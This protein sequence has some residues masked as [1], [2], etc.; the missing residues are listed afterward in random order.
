LTIG[1]ISI[2]ETYSKLSLAD[3]RRLKRLNA[4]NLLNY[5][6]KRSVLGTKIPADDLSTLQSLQK[7][8]LVLTQEI[9]RLASTERQLPLP[10]RPLCIGRA[11]D[12]TTIQNLLENEQRRASTVSIEGFGGIGKTVLAKETAHLIQGRGRYDKIIWMSAK[13]SEFINGSITPID[14]YSNNLSDLLDV[15][16]ESFGV[17]DISTIESLAKKASIARRHL[18]DTKTLVIIDNLETVADFNA[19]STFLAD[20]PSP[21]RALCTSRRGLLA[22]AIPVRLTSLNQ[23]ESRTLARAIAEEWKIELPDGVADAIYKITYGVPL[24]I[25]LVM[26]PLCHQWS[27]ATHALQR[28]SSLPKGLGPLLEFAF[29]DSYAALDGDAQRILK[30]VSLFHEKTTPLKAD[31]PFVAAVEDLAS[32]RSFDQLRDLALIDGGDAEVTLHP[33]TRAL[34]EQ[35][36]KT[37]NGTSS[38]LNLPS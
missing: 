2:G 20:L 5:E 8:A 10:R 18:G 13:R 31:L 27:G 22:G 1:S 9:G 7:E 12:L 26:A 17:D 6:E 33:L 29:S 24:A 32:E 15:V 25:N 38:L 34:L 4:Q 36:Y 19:M 14:T 37:E 28:I 11:T 3:L 21:S 16:G 30:A 23:Q 35:G